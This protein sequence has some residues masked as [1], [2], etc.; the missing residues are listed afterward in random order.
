L[1]EHVE[2]EPND[3]GRTLERLLAVLDKEVPASSVLHHPLST[4]KIALLMRPQPCQRCRARFSVQ[5]ISY[6]G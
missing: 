4:K 3:P 1:A 2:L 6:L 5:S